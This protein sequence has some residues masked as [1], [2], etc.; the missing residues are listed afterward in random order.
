MCD[1]VTNLFQAVYL[2]ERHKYFKTTAGRA[3]LQAFADE[4]V[5]KKRLESYF[6]ELGSWERSTNYFGN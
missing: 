3:A 5:N 4:Q 1:D 6:K 2:L